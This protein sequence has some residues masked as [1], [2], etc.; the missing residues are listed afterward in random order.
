MIT[1]QTNC[2]SKEDQRLLFKSH[3]QG[4]TTDYNSR[5]IGSVLVSSVSKLAVCLKSERLIPILGGHI[6]I[7]QN[8]SLLNSN[9][10]TVYLLKGHAHPHRCF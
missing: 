7:R 9:S 6:L 8:V 3:R 5:F 4:Y 1:E 2:I 10:A